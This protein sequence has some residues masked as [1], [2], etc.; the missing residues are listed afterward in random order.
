VPEGTGNRDPQ[1][2]LRRNATSYVLT[3]VYRPVGLGHPHLDRYGQP[4]RAVGYDLDP[5]RDPALTFRVRFPDGFEMHVLPEEVDDSVPGAQATGS[6]PLAEKVE[7]A[8]QVMLAARRDYDGEADLPADFY[9]DDSAYGHAL[10]GLREVL[11][12]LSLRRP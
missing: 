7:Y 2:N 4:C 5:E 12:L 1:E 8:I 11:N 10:Q 3:N 6:D 9:D